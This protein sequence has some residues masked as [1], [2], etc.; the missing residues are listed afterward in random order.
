[1]SAPKL[2]MGMF[3]SAKDDWATP[4]DLFAALN[5]R[6]S[7]DLD[8]CASVENAKC[9]RFFTREDDGLLQLWHG[10]V[11][12]NPPYG[13]VLGDWVKKA[14]QEVAAG[15]AGVAVALIPARTDTG[16][17]H[18]YVMQAS[19]V[20]LLRGRVHHDHAGHDGPA[21]NAPFP[22]AVVV[23]EAGSSGPPTFSAMFAKPAAL[24]PVDS[25]AQG[26][27]K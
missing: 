14:Y 12:M 9:S 20:I 21:H 4:A 19:E 16:Y 13:R 18:D 27:E 3:P 25:R 11:F 5:N 22:S 8:P 6:F 7:F 17:W 10:R 26:G 23:F 1:M 15:R 24:H 2:N